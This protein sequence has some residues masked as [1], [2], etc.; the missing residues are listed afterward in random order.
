ML[1]PPHQD[2]A[3][4][5]SQ[6]VGCNTDQDKEFCISGR[7]Q[8]EPDPRRDLSCSELVRLPSC[9]D[10]VPLEEV[11]LARTGR[12]FGSNWLFALTL[13]RRGPDVDAANRDGF[14]F[15]AEMKKLPGHEY[16]AMVLC[17]A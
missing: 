6:D 14:A 5:G 4:N 11:L 17:E 15:R 8:K 2:E 16:A 12:M 13:P 1:E 3:A 7:Y 9:I 10:E